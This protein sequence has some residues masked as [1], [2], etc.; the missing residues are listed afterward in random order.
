LVLPSLYENLGGI[1]LE[2]QACE[3]PVIATDV[4]GV[5]EI[6]EDGKTGFMLNERSA[7]ELAETLGMILNDVRIIY[8]N[9]GDPAD[10]TGKRLAEVREVID[11]GI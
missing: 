3:C 1:L 9:R 2:A 10:L 11:K 6:V 8:L 5:K 7:E 4:G